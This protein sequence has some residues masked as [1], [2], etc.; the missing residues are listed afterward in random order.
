MVVE[1]SD[2]CSYFHAWLSARMAQPQP[3]YRSIVHE[4]M[5]MLTYYGK[6]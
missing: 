1:C 2:V 5:H 4:F 3:D 6:V